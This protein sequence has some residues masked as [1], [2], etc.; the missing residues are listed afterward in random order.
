MENPSGKKRHKWDIYKED[1]TCE[2][3]GI[4]RRKV[5]RTTYTGIVRGILMEYY[6]NGEWKIMP[7]PNCVVINETVE[8]GINS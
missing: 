1:D 5:A 4:K 3:C 6:I 8:I 2:K 7:A